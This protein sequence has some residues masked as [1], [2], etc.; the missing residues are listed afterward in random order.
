MS[1]YESYP[2]PPRVEPTRRPPRAAVYAVALVGSVAGTLAAVWEELVRGAWLA[3]VLVG[4]AVEEIAKPIA[5]VYLLE[6]RPHWLRSGAEVFALAVAGA[7][8]F[9][10]L[11]NLLYVFVYHPAAGAGFVAFRF[12][13]CTAL[14]LTAT[15][16]FAVG[17]VKVWRRIRLDG[18]PFDIDQCFRYYV[19]AVAIHAAYNTT[20][21]VLAHAGVRLF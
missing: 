6:R 4:P 8:V 10:T 12:G 18:R 19:A 21:L 9:A 13:V 2:P 11:E 7:C 20:V 16:A 15:G 5:I 3:V 14:H 17:L 1:E